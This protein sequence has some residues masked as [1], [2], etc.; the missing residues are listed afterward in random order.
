MP[1]ASGITPTHEGEQDYA[2]TNPWR[3]ACAVPDESRPR[4]HPGMSLRIG[5]SS[6]ALYP[7]VPTERVPERAAQ[8][9]FREIELL[10][11]TSGEYQAEFLRGVRSAADS[12]GV[13]IRSL[14]LYQSLHPLLTAYQRRTDEALELF[15]RAIDGARICGA[16]VLVWHGAARAEATTPDAWD[17]FVAIMARLAE[18]CAGTGIT[19]GIENVSWCVISSV[20]DVLRLNGELAVI[21][22]AAAIGY[23]FDSFQAHEADANPFM[24]L[25]A[26]EGRLANVHISDG[27][28]AD[29]RHRHLLPGQGELPWPALIKAIA[30]AGYSGPLMLEASVRDQESVD[31]VRELLDPLL[32]LAAGDDPCA[33]P[34]PDG[35]RSGIAL[36]NDGQYYEAHEVIEHEWHAERRSIRV[37]YQ[38]ILQIGVGLHHARGGNHRGAV[39]L[40]GDGIA[41][42]G[43]FLPSCQG[44]QTAKLAV[45]AQR[46]LDQILE[47][48]PE[49]LADF[50]WNLAPIVEIQGSGVRGQGLGDR[51]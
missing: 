1:P 30:G 10:L 22:N 5:L 39:L 11:Q 31:R 7:D 25:A 50:D 13:E 2:N 24:L 18:L 35:V 32:H 47:L 21:P 42:V 16:G 44:V 23:V 29:S 9:G 40:L 28:S 36:F 3:S 37:L 6:G 20:R 41:K 34:L 33:E 15:K 46:C 43:R 17:R 51:C 14:H 19:L 27:Q 8:L 12:G 26:M 48:G 4:E 49:G 45:Q 38:G